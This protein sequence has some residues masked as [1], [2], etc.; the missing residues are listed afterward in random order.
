MQGPDTSSEDMFNT[1]PTPS[2]QPQSR[3]IETFLPSMDESLDE[4]YLPVLR[5]RPWALLDP[6]HCCRYRL[7]C[8][9]RRYNV[10]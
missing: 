1:Y 3:D 10:G 7:S 2:Q 9:Y 6:L 8:C 4:E 5:K